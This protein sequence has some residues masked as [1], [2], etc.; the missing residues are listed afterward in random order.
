VEKIGRLSRDQVRAVAEAA[1]R[2]AVQTKDN[3]ADLINVALEEL[4]R[5]S[6]ELPGYTDPAASR[7]VQRS[8]GQSVAGEEHDEH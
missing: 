3:P 6:C 2:A 7:H 4:V 8:G 5:A 1:I